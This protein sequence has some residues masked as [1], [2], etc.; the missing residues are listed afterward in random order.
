MAKR[1][2]KRALSIILCLV[3]IA[4]TFFIF[5]PSILIKDADAYA[6]VESVNSSAKLALQTAYAPETIY[7][8]PGSTAFQYFCNYN[9]ANGRVSEAKS[10]S[11]SITFTNQDAT[12]VQLAVNKVYYKNG[13]TDVALTPSNLKI[14]STTISTVANCG[15][16]ST[17]FASG[18][19]VLASGTNSISY[20]V[21]AGSLS[22]YSQG[23]VYYIQWV[24]RYVID[25]S[26]RLA[27]MYTAIYAPV[28][29]MTAVASYN[30]NTGTGDT[31]EIGMFAF[32]TG[33][34][35]YAEKGNRY[36][37]FTGSTIKA[38][39]TSTGAGTRTAP[40]VSFVGYKNS[41]SA[42]TI[43][44]EDYNSTNNFPTSDTGSGKTVLV[45][46]GSVNSGDP[47]YYTDFTSYGS[48]ANPN[49]TGTISGDCS[50]S[51]FQTGVAYMVVDTSRF[52][53]YNQIPN[54][55]AGFVTTSKKKGGN[56][57]KLY[58]IRGLTTARGAMSESEVVSCSPDTGDY[59]EDGV[60]S[61]AYGL[62]ALNG[63][64][65]SGGFLLTYHY[66]HSISLGFGLGSRAT[67][68]ET[69]IGIHT[70]TINKT[71]LRETYN[72]ALH[73][74]IDLVNVNKAK[75]ALS[76]IDYTTYYNQLKSAGE[77][78][79]DP[80]A[81]L[82]ASADSTLKGYVDTYSDA[83]A[84]T[85]GAD[86]YFYVPE[87]IYTKPLGTTTSSTHYGAT[88]V[89]GT[90]NS[91]THTITNNTGEQKWG[92]IYFYYAN[93][94]SVKVSFS[95]I[96]SASAS[97]SG[98]S[99]TYADSNSATSG[100]TFYCTGY[101]SSQGISASGNKLQKYIIG[102]SA[103]I[104]GTSTG[105]WLKWTATYVD[106]TD[107][108]TKTATAYT[109]VY[110]TFF[111]P[112][113][114]AAYNENND[115]IGSG[116]RAHFGTMAWVS[117]IHSITSTNAGNKYTKTTSDKYMIP[118]SYANQMGSGSTIAAS[119]N[120]I[121]IGN[122]YTYP[123][124]DTSGQYFTQPNGSDPV[125]YLEDSRTNAN[126]YSISNKNAQYRSRN[127]GDD[128][129]LEYMTMPTATMTVDVSRYTNLN[130]V[131]GFSVGI[132][133]S[134][135]RSQDASRF[136]LGDY[137]GRTIRG[138]GAN[139][140][141]GN[142]QDW[143]KEGGTVF[144]GNAA[145]GHDGSYNGTGVKYNGKG[146]VALT[147]SASSKTYAIKGGATQKND[148]E[149]ITHLYYFQISVTQYN[150]ANLRKAY[151]NAINKS[152]QID[153]N[154]F[155][156]DS[157]CW[158]TYES[159][160]EAAG[161]ALTQVD[162]II[163]N[164]DTLATN[165]NNAVNHLLSESKN[166]TKYNGGSCRI[167]GTV[168][169][170]HRYLVGTGSSAKSYEL[171][172]G[173]N[174]TNLETRTYFYGDTVKTG[175]NE[176]AGYDYIGYYRNV[177]TTQWTSSANGSLVGNDRGPNMYGSSGHTT[178]KNVVT[179]N[180][181]YTYVYYRT[182][183]SVFKDYGEAPHEYGKTTNYAKLSTA[184]INNSY[185]NW[186]INGGSANVTVAS[187]T[188]FNFSVGSIGTYSGNNSIR[189]NDILIK[190]AAK[191]LTGGKKYTISFASNLGYDV[192]HWFGKDYVT[193]SWSI[194]EDFEY[195][196]GKIQAYVGYTNGSDDLA[197]AVELHEIQT[198]F[199]D[200]GA[201]GTFE[202][203]AGA[204]NINILFRIVSDGSAAHSGTISNIKIV[205]GEY[206][207]MGYHGDKESLSSP[208]WEGHSIV[209]WSP[210]NDNFSGALSGDR[211]SV[212]TYGTNDDVVEASWQI[213]NYDVGFDNEFDFDT[214]VW[215]TPNTA[216]Q[217]VDYEENSITLT[218]SGTDTYTAPYVGTGQTGYMTLIPG[219]TY[220]FSYKYEN[221]SVAGS[222]FPYVFAY[223]DTSLSDYN[224][225]IKSW[226]KEIAAN[227]SG[228]H[229]FTWTIPSGR[230][231]V[232]MRL[233]LTA[234][235]MVTKF[236]DIYI[237]DVTGPF[238]N[239]NNSTLR[240]PTVNG[241]T[242]HYA[243]VEYS[244]QLKTAGQ[245]NGVM[246]TT[247]YT[248]YNF[249]GWYDSV[250]STGNGVGTKYEL[251]TP[252]GAGVTRLHSRWT[253]G[254][255]YN[256]NG[257]SY[258]DSNY[259]VKSRSSINIGTSIAVS[260]RVAQGSTNWNSSSIS[261]SYV[262]YRVGYNFAGW[263]AS[264]VDPAVNGKVYWPG[265]NV[266]AKAN[267]TFTAQWTT[268]ES[269][270]LS[271][272]SFVGTAN[273]GYTF[274]P[275]QIYF[276]KFSPSTNMQV[277]AY[278]YESGDGDT[279]VDP[280]I[281][282]YTGTSLTD[283][284]DDY[285]ESFG[286]VDIQEND[287]NSSLNSNMTAGTTYYY[288]L[289]LNGNSSHN[290]WIY[291]FNIEENY[292]NYTLNANG[293]SGAPSYVT[294][295][296]NT[297]TSVTSPIKTGY[298]FA[299]W[300]ASDNSSTYTGSVPAADTSSRINNNRSTLVTNVTLTAQWNINQYALN[301]YAQF[302]KA[303]S[304]TAKTS[305][306]ERGTTG[307]T[308]KITSG[309][310]AGA[311]AST[312]LNYQTT[313]TIVATP[314]T[315]YT[316][317]G[318]YAAPTL[319]GTTVTA[320]GTQYASTTT[321]TTSAMG[322]GGLNYYAKFEIN[323]YTIGIYAYNNS[324]AA[325]G[326]YTQGTTGGSVGFTTGA[327]S[328]GTTRTN[329]HGQSVTIYAKPA[330]GY[331]F[332]G[333][334][335]G[336]TASM[337]SA[338]SIA[339]G[340]CLLANG[341]YSYTW[342]TTDSRNY[343]AKFSINQYTLT[344]NPN[345]GTYA[346][347]TN[348]STVTQY[349][350]TTYTVADPS[351]TGYTFKSW[352][353]AKTGGGTATGSISNKVYTFGAGNDTITA[354]WA[355][356]NYG[357]TVNPNGGTVPNM[358]YY[359]AAS[360]AA[361]GTLTSSGAFTASTT[362][363]MAYNTTASITAPTRTGYTFAGWSR[364]AGNG[365][366]TN[367]SPV[368]TANASFK[369]TN[370]TATITA[371]WTVNQYTL[372][373]KA[374][375]NTAAATG[376]FA[377]NTTGGS[378]KIGS[379][380]SGATET[381]SVNYGST[382]QITA[383]AATGYTFKG[384]QTTVPTSAN[385]S[386]LYS[387]NNPATTSAMGTGGLTYYARFEINSYTVTV[388]AAYNTAAATGTYTAGTTGGTVSGGGSKYYNTQASLTASA[389]T[390]YS[391]SGWFSSLTA[392][393]PVSTASPYTPTITSNLTL[394]AKFS[395]R[396][397]TVSAKAYGNSA[398]G[399]TTFTEGVG[400]T[401]S[402]AGKVYYNQ[403][404]S[405]TA[406]AKT[407]YTF[408]GWYTS[409]NVSGT[410]VSTSATYTP[411][412]TGDVTYYA[413]FTVKIS[414]VNVYAYGNS[415]ADLS[416]Y[417]LGVG[418]NVNTDGTETTT[419]VSKEFYYG[420]IY[421]VRAYPATGYAFGGWYSDAALTKE[422]TA[423][424]SESGGLNQDYYY[425][426]FIKQD[427]TENVYAKFVVQSYNL[428]VYAY[429][430]TGSA[431]GTYQNSATGG[432]VKIIASSVVTNVTGNGTLKATAKVV[433]G[434]AA[435]ITA[436]AAT[437]Y[438]FGGWYTSSNVS[439]TAISTS[440]SITLPAMGV[441][442]LV[443][444]A[445]FN[446]G[447][448]KI[449]FNAN[450]GTA[451]T[452]TSGTAYYNTP[453]DIPTA[454]NPSRTGYAFLGW[455]TSSTATAADFQSGTAIPAATINS[456]YNTD[457]TLYAVWK[458]TAFGVNIYSAYDEY[459]HQGSYLIGTVGGT[460]TISGS[461]IN[462]YDN[463][464]SKITATPKTGY[465]V[466][467][468]RYSSGIVPSQGNSISINWGTQGNSET[469]MPTNAI[470]IVVYFRL[471]S[472]D[473]NV[474]SYSN[475]AA[476][477]GTY[478]NNAA[479]GTVRFGQ[480][481]T[482]GASAKTTAIYGATVLA[483]AAPSTGYKFDNWYSDSTLKTQVGTSTS[484]TITVGDSS[485]NANANKYYAKFSII[486][487]TAYGSARYY[488]QGFD[489]ASG[490]GYIGTDGGTVKISNNNSTWVT[491]SGNQKASV[492]V[493]YNAVVYYTAAANTGYEFIGWFSGDDAD[494]FTDPT[495]ATTANYSTTMPAES[496]DIHA[497]FTPYNF[498]LVLNPNGGVSGATVVI[499]LTYNQDTRIPADGI[500]TR[501]GY[502]FEGWSDSTTGA[503]N[504][505]YNGLIPYTVVNSWFDTSKKEESQKTIYAVWSEALYTVVLDHQNNS[506]VT[507][508]TVKVGNAM[509]AI[510]V[511]TYSGYNFGGYY[512]GTGGDGQRYYDENGKG[513]T[514]WNIK[515]GATLYAK[516]TCP[517]LNDVEYKNGSWTYT[518]EATPSGT[519][520]KNSSTA[521]TDKDGITKNAPSGAKQI[522]SVEKTVTDSV[523][524][525]IVATKDINLNH[526]KQAALDELKNSVLATNTAKKLA[527]LN[528]PQINEYVAK[529]AKNM[530][531]DFADNKKTEKI[532][533]S[534]KIYETGS[535]LSKIKG[536]TIINA[537]D[538]A[539]GSTYKYPTSSEASSYAFTG[540]WSSTANSAVDY[541]LYTN[542]ATPV[543]ALEID[544]G[545]VGTTVAN[546]NS[547]YPTDVKFSGIATSSS[548]VSKT[549]YD[550]GDG[551]YMKSAVK[552][553][554]DITTAWFYSYTQAGIGTNYDYNAKTVYYLTPTFSSPGTK[555]E[556]VYTISPSD[557]AIV[558]N[559]GV[560]SSELADTT[561]ALKSQFSS[562]N[563]DVKD[564]D[565]ITICISY[566]NSMNGTSDEGSEESSGRYLQMKPDQV[567]RDVWLKQ[568]RMFRT[569]GGAS[570][571]EFPRTNESVYPVDDSTFASTGYVLGSFL[572]VFDSTNEPEATAYAAAG[573]QQATKQ[574]IINSVKSN[575][576]EAQAA[577]MDRSN[578]SN[579]NS[580]K[581]K[582][583]YADV[584][585]WNVNIYP[586]EGSY[587]YAHLVDRW[588]NVFNRV[589]KCFNVDGISSTISG[590]TDSVYDIFE[591][592]GSLLDTISLNGANVEFITDLDSS[593]DNGVFTTTGGSFT[594]STGE[595]NKSYNITIND[596][597]GNSTA[598]TVKSDAN[599]LVTF[600]V[601]DARA[602]LALGAY[603]FDFNGYTV[604]LYARD[605]ALV[606]DA[607]ITETSVIGSDTVITVITASDATK[608]QLV[609]NGTT[610]TYTKFSGNV[611]VTE[612]ADGTLTWNIARRQNLG[613][614]S[615]GIRAKGAK[616]WEDS[617]FVV[618]TQIIKPAQT[619]VTALV[620]ADDA[621]A[622]VGNRPSVKVKVKE[623]TQSIR[624]IDEDGST[625]TL[626]KSSSLVTVASSVDGIETWY[627]SLPSSGIETTRTY[628]VI[629]RYNGSWQR[630]NSKSVV[631]T[632]EKVV[633]PV[634]IYSVTL[635]SDEVKA[636]EFAEFELITSGKISKICL[637]RENGD[638]AT[639][640]A[641]NAVVTDLSDGTKEWKINLKFYA[642][643]TASL[644]FKV[645]TN[646]GWSDTENYGTVDVK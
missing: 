611:T 250:D 571:W 390:G 42:N 178:D 206:T 194:W 208:V 120:S 252:I 639:Y 24:I 143:Y 598:S 234:V 64:I 145:W 18:T 365:T 245:L 217:V 10:T 463:L 17:A 440:A 212:Y 643:G 107:G 286:I 56:R 578:P 375:S 425:R 459:T 29:N 41:T 367:G 266:V 47:R 175:Y 172:V 392:T 91:T 260:N 239:T 636:G 86:V 502:T 616:G 160:L 646:A 445:K 233:G 533:P 279:G 15:A 393:S 644:D 523:N 350:K 406:T 68:P 339:V 389:K 441:A 337:G 66:E 259:A 108:R 197:S 52:T 431:L 148:D 196:S 104:N 626:A 496:I 394:Y 613:S 258:R 574:A 438:T 308:V 509:P 110:K 408:A 373:V 464:W 602:N 426:R 170:Y 528:Q 190:N 253:V 34:M 396:Q 230:P 583:G 504:S 318:W 401:I 37:A 9:V 544:D 510:T 187:D 404:A 572:Y 94:S 521:I 328:S 601:E 244:Q 491:A 403:K 424:V 33:A 193:N 103:Y 582:L 290:S 595:P 503:V 589:W 536:D 57:S 229:S 270:G 78:L 121:K 323:T 505:V 374:Y 141:S 558:A 257:G 220:S 132:M 585:V 645:K 16:T 467:Q 274:F 524:K 546:N 65:Y 594:V 119:T 177:G 534:I 43:P 186:G 51:G 511:P 118:Y 297:A 415:G 61:R 163:T 556:I 136:Y 361:S 307:G 176:T 624:F 264:S 379:G 543:I 5:D 614:Y 420:A 476:A 192:R 284:N 3:L 606:R 340:S 454:A 336:N 88:Y 530:S 289:G 456:W 122:L 332:G 198:E 472:F 180:L 240:V 35:K 386:S 131:P 138:N 610:A 458:A 181:T 442:G 364:T 19:T 247:S 487:Y 315:G 338:A 348:N 527:A 481:G 628:T 285:E 157:T 579:I 411:A 370:S 287:Y 12:Q 294:G 152:N 199:T 640:S 619:V 513:T 13:T 59:D 67:E 547:S 265:Q 149:Y 276:Y 277:T 161:K 432:N 55:S 142:S 140:S 475:S 46:G 7:L 591:D 622:I 549:A 615:F 592:G 4:T 428:T 413:K 331:T 101:N 380:A 335:Y 79:C 58:W 450:G 219:H 490:A 418:G 261:Y 480:T 96:G 71:S 126:Y 21:T 44:N 312:K 77:K 293:G 600:N 569:S 542:S 531:I 204:T 362:F 271:D 345:G 106:K 164:P 281:W 455:S 114:G 128:Y 99:I 537:S 634:E 414:K 642:S 117:G 478:Q 48:F 412:V 434:Q 319:S 507:E 354:Q 541:Y 436:T 154:I 203:P 419:S 211:N 84:A 302:N 512:T 317:G 299:G 573:N 151:L 638:T 525:K 40:L 630:D 359:N 443:R 522:T 63:P 226:T 515:G 310:T 325:P 209:T 363:Q 473:V 356:N 447:S 251:T 368:T 469:Q 466:Y 268:C 201:M 214:W 275:G 520:A 588:G 462:A 383:T 262:P 50:A 627:A 39:G 587:V 218:S 93:A 249:S 27:F 551:Y 360:G 298:T 278:T 100:T 564:T 637:V 550:D 300:K 477:T 45:A 565:S 53:N 316:F 593:F 483:I 381:A 621:T 351:R 497:K 535:K 215:G 489:Y 590:G 568:M 256:T 54:L 14:N 378:V 6:N 474:Y 548:N 273:G 222:L 612:N 254:I 540:K 347:T 605:P 529:I 346:G 309:G 387:T 563:Y 552:A 165:L 112:I 306:Y 124:T 90:V 580:S 205:E 73:T 202:L 137:T 516:W 402:G 144:Y 167:S 98:N 344:I 23:G 493:Y 566:H 376:T 603:S 188:Q 97:S 553:T 116:N 241:T 559:E 320:W 70:T 82:N 11:G 479:G 498:T 562:F 423:N 2:G 313:T 609:Y 322:T 430:N 236:S 329:V 60:Y 227:E 617:D 460:A 169:V 410:A 532:E 111:L 618:T 334:Y 495:L 109:Y 26:P 272:P 385:G 49:P 283:D 625:V 304:A 405:L 221:G 518:Y 330:T 255:T 482:Q 292:V 398:T 499:T 76:T 500:P 243:T 62:Y 371:S 159:A 597:A 575:P 171:N 435:T 123:F 439:G 382:A 409:S 486:S 162:G 444:Y 72:A 288:G 342:T 173:D 604:N 146:S 324:A 191:G 514:T 358:Q 156:T 296:Y 92:N 38:W 560:N 135:E 581:T 291:S 25:G 267:I 81:Y 130:Q 341:V 305:T 635:N 357:I 608:V 554:D 427:A 453:F 102:S 75:T 576:S 89:D 633:E 416:K 484:L 545:K 596:H 223:A 225:G 155:H 134:R 74:N 246:P 333:W 185:T 352:S 519:T 248:G 263:K 182:K 397:Y 232:T 195:T 80:T 150:K 327:G 506:G 355:V 555:S 125:D 457:R 32:V 224:G 400:G 422:A 561:S 153:A 311:S 133:L 372:T 641:S 280:H 269:I 183:N 238:V 303:S 620:S 494:I 343:S 207:R 468:W 508:I 567:Y 369:V 465:A 449:N 607:S 557:D 584:D 570:N 452:T 95:V 69:S 384:W 213:N 282:L 139:S 321:A 87:A 36:N 395:I 349:Y 437:G 200:G 1:M 115:G 184:E 20:R 470:N 501:L 216:T 129:L 517:I 433:Y 127:S 30:R 210:K 228:T 85:N 448:F 166:C 446:V 451:G 242:V 326:T 235:G 377:N 353:I 168:R 301:V 158:K 391:F 189:L 8:K 22:G 295:H 399:L 631:V 417:T 366:L 586:K 147:T 538:S 83:I 421:T 488:T 629:A 314:A 174:G 577:I 461:T 429:N 388:T 407:G 105:M 237:Q 539:N 231:Y 623:G 485:K 179:P 632:F 31:P 492:S 113:A 599:G 28:L 471:S 526:Y